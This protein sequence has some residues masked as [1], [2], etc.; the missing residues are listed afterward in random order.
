V[1]IEKRTI[2][3]LALQ[4]NWGIKKGTKKQQE[5][6]TERNGTNRGRTKKITPRLLVFGAGV[7]T[8]L[9]MAV[10]E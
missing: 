4:R 7:L 2:E 10:D 3:T 8:L 9:I 6:G 1:L 5:N